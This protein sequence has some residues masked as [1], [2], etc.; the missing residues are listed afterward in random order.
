MSENQYKDAAEDGDTHR[1]QSINASSFISKST[2]GDALI[3]ASS[4]GKIAVVRYLLKKN[5]GGRDVVPLEDRSGVNGE[6]ALHRAAMNGHFDVVKALLDADANAEAVANKTST[7]ALY[8]KCKMID[9]AKRG[10]NAEANNYEKILNL[11]LKYSEEPEATQCH[12]LQGNASRIGRK[13]GGSRKRNLKRKKT[14]KN[15]R[16]HTRRA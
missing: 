9:N 10:N 8:A 5:S 14:R 3:E 13:Y 7:P 4:K 12:R 1:M 11:L 6:T 2:Y 15:K 16:R